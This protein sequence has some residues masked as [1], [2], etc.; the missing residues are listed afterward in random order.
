MLIKNGTN[1]TQ[2]YTLP[3]DNRIKPCVEWLDLF[4]KFNSISTSIAIVIPIINTILIMMMK[5]LAKFEKNKTLTQEL[6]STTWKMFIL[7]FINTGLAI[8]LVNMLIKSVKDNIKD[9]P[10]FT[11]KFSDLD[12]GW[13]SVVGV[14]ILFSMLLNIIVPHVSVAAGVLITYVFRYLD[15]GFSCGKKT[16][17]KYKRNYLELYVGPEF[18]IEVRYSGMLTTMYISLIYSSGM[19]L[20]YLCILGYLLFTF[21]VDKLLSILYLNF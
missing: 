9:F 16:K 8:V 2:L 17:I 11:G 13:Y 3:Q 14:T 19:P 7:Q 21:L 1:V 18:P 15:S 4:L 5:F 12:P 6:L 20:M 10:L